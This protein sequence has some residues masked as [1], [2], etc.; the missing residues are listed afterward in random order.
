VTQYLAV[1]GYM[2][3]R[4]RILIALR[5][6]RLFLISKIICFGYAFSNCCSDFK[7]QY[8]FFYFLK[9]GLLQCLKPILTFVFIIFLKKILHQFFYNFNENFLNVWL[10]WRLKLLQL[11][12]LFWR[13]QYFLCTP[14]I[15]RQQLYVNSEFCSLSILYQYSIISYTCNLD[16]MIFNIQ[17]KIWNFWILSLSIDATGNWSMMKLWYGNYN[18]QLWPVT[19]CTCLHKNVVATSSNWHSGS[20]ADLFYDLKWYVGSDILGN[21]IIMAMTYLNWYV[22]FLFCLCV[23]VV[24]RHCI[25]R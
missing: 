3:S 1:G 5:F 21:D 8:A 17:Y 12:V 19:T 23:T 7:I 4:G 14:K 2:R 25:G 24:L 18:W 9:V 20:W 10:I 13:L 16:F 22:A 15:Y 11:I 6:L